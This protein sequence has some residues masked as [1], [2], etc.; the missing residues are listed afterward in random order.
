MSKDNLIDLTARLKQKSKET[1]VKGNVKAQVLDLVER[2]QDAIVQERRALKRTILTEFIGF[3]V[4]TEKGL[5]S[6]IPLYDIS[7]NGIS[8]E[9][10]I[11]IPLVNEG[12][13]VAVRIYMTQKT[14]F[15]FNIKVKNIRYT[16]DDGIYRYGAEFMKDD[17]KKEALQN[18]IKFIESVSQHLRADNGDLAT[19]FSR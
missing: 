19:R 14:Y 2:R 8:F 1:P 7:K 11:K 12:Q 16:N 10:P 6:D 4:V 9:T 3:S 5:V 18:F 17:T 13:E 15:T